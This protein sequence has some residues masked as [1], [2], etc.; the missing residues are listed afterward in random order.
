M[1][2]HRRRYRLVARSGRAPRVDVQPAAVR[3][4][5]ENLHH[6]GG[7]VHEGDLFSP[8]PAALRGRI[9]L[10]VVNAPYVPTAEVELLPRE[11]RLYEPRVTLDGGPDGLRIH[12]LVTA[13]APRWL[14][15]G[16]HLLFETTEQQALPLAEELAMH[17]LDATT[18]RSDELETTAVVGRRPVAV[19]SG[20]PASDAHTLGVRDERAQRQ[21]P[22]RSMK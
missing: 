18:I 10:L 3:C 6:V 1:R 7:S 15:P 8:L 16:G 4:A 2:R 9:D 13:E 14:A 11:A 5:R 22:S 19:T 12:R 17:G 21:R 20:V